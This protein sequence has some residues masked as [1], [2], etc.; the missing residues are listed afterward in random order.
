MASFVQTYMPPKADKLVKENI[1]KNL[2][3]RLDY[4]SRYVIETFSSILIDA[5]EYPATRMFR[6]Y[7]FTHLFS[8]SYS[9]NDAFTL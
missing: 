6:I 1:S 8:D 9:R 4:P 2:I 7:I 3:G 5:D